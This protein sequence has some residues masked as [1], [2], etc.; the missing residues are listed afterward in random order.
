MLEHDLYAYYKAEISIQQKIKQFIRERGIEL[1]VAIVG[2]FI[3]VATVL[4]S[5]KVGLHQEILQ[6][7]RMTDSYFNGVAELFAKSADEN[8][9]I[10]LLIIARTEALIEDLH[11]L[12]KPTK[13][14]SVITF[15]SNLKPG[16]FYKDTRA[17]NPR[18]S[19]IYLGEINLSGSILRNIHLEN[20]RFPYSNLSE[21]DLSHSNLQGALL[22]KANLQRANL[23]YTSFNNANLQGANLYKATID[24]TT[25]ENANLENAIWINGLRCQAGSI[26][27]CIQS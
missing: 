26:G 4:V 19:Y 2:L 5:Y 1:T 9:K 20:A 24:N 16:L 10:N 13:L 23:R 11:E 21:C 14:A 22:K 12:K 18:E 6:A 8:Q 7:S 25:F 3:G 27:K 17:D 15:V